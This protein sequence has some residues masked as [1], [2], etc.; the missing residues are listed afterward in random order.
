M[1]R[2]TLLVLMAAAWRLLAAQPF[3]Q[4]ALE[5]AVRRMGLTYRAITERVTRSYEIHLRLNSPPAPQAR[6]SAD[7][8]RTVFH[9]SPPPRQRSTEMSRDQLLILALDAQHAVRYWQIVMNPC[10]IRGEFPDAGGNLH[11]TELYR[12]NCE[13]SAYLPDGSDASEVRV[14]VPSWP[15]G[16]IEFT[17]LVSV[18]I[19]LNRR[20]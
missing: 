4:Q 14:L 2:L 8:I 17:M 20:P 1:R 5:Q 7:V 3:D 11:K 13:L 15:N 16:A 10:L 18:P 12:P 19:A 6:F 9:N